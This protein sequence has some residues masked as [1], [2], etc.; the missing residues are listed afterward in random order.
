VNGDGH[1]T[2]GFSNNSAFRLGATCKP[3][4]KVSQNLRDRILLER[5]ASSLDCGSIY[6]NSSTVLD[7]RVTGLSTLTSKIVPFFS[8]YPLSGAKALDFADFCRGIDIMNSRGHLTSA[9]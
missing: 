1:F 9:G 2:L 8:Q 7:L 5:I 6:P 3:L 4:F